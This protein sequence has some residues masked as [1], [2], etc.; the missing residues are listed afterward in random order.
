M[1]PLVEHNMKKRA[2]EPVIS[3]IIITAIILLIVAIVISYANNA[4]AI[5]MAQAEFEQAK[6][7]TISLAES[8]EEVASKPSASSYVRYNARAGG[9]NFL[10][11]VGNIEVNVN[12]TKVIKGNLNEFRY[13]GGSLASTTYSIL[14]GTDEFIIINNT[15]PLGRVY[16]KQADGAYVILDF[17][18]ILVLNLGF[19]NM[20]SAKGYEIIH[21][22]QISFINL[23]IGSTQGTG[24]INVVA[25]CTK[26]QLT[27]YDI[28][29]PKPQQPYK[30]QINVNITGIQSSYEL[31]VEKPAGYNFVNG[32]RI[33]VVKSD[34]ELYSFGG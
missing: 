19:F 22:V 33:I 25:K 31:N 21:Y 23:T 34:V 5:Q 3:T 26:N 13:K 6:R 9:P 27:Y 7:I 16:T 11:N 20:S 24:S 4:L 14:R 17:N 8:I 15:N 10:R 1:H 32:T 29:N 28:I 2:V 30:I 18:R 12:G